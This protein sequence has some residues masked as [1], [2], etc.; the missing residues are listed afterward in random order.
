MQILH[1][2]QAGIALPR[3]SCVSPRSSQDRGQ[4]DAPSQGGP[5][6]DKK[7]DLIAIVGAP[8]VLDDPATL[9]AWSRDTS[10]SVPRQPW[11]V[12]RPQGVE[13]VQALV[14]WANETRTPLVPVSSGGPHCHGG[15]VPSVPEAV[16]VDLSRMKAILKI[17]RRNRM[18]YVE[19][20]VTYAD[21]A[22]ALA[23][24]GLRIASPLQARQS[25]SVLASLLDRNPTLIPRLN[26]SLPE[27]LRALGVVWGTGDLAFTGDAGNGPTSLEA[28]WQHNLAQI[29]PKGPNATDLMRL[30]TGAQGTMGIAVWASVRCELMPVARGY[31]FVPGQTLAELVPFCHRLERMRLGD[32]V[33]TLNAA[34]AA[35]LFAAEPGQVK[36]LQARLP[37]WCVVVGLSGAALFP[38]ERVQVQENDLKALAQSF[39]LGLLPALPGVSHAQV[40]KALYGCSPETYWKLAYKGA[41]QEVF[42][43][44]T[45]DKAP[46]FLET[47]KAIASELGFPDQDL[48]VYIQP[49]HQGTSQHVEFNLPYDPACAKETALVQT[50]FD[51]ASAALLAQG[52]YFSRPYGTWA[53]P[54][55]NR[56]ATAKQVLRVVKG[57]LDPKNVLNP[58]KLCF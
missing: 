26:F 41:N 27:P 20:G 57:I 33:F 32:E 8:H 21:L 3:E 43:L 16:I 45:L 4:P 10:F 40:A 29:D 44:T 23:K 37:Q 51:R 11:F 5:E 38:E 25:K 30:M 36:A 58:G 53:A 55:Y 48:G 50:L 9:E 6:V 18:A 31:F 15:T 1:A 2:A 28:Q 12:V 13:Q 46:G 7:T 47:V 42:F 22:P 39:S 24:E 49:Q 34:Q 52:A 56:D 17:D 54:V 19:P 35:Q 14:R